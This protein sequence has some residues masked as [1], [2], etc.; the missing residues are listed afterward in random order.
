MG[1]F[2]VQ[3]YF[4]ALITALFFISCSDGENFKSLDYKNYNFSYNGFEKTLKLDQKN[5]NFA[6]VFFT[7]DCGVCKEQIKILQQLIQNYNFNIFVILGNAKNLNDAKN[8]AQ[9]K[10]LTQLTLFYEKN[11]AKYLS[12]AIGGIYGVPVISFFEAGKMNKKF[13]GLTPYH[14]LE[15]EIKRIK[16]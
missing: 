13:I 6:L 4:I 2:K 3:A 15:N 7:K 11:A 14:I 8:W 10:G 9:D 5:Q 12:D 1:K 16:N